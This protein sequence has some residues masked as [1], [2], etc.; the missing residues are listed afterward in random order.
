MNTSIIKKD[1]WKS[2]EYIEFHLD[3][4]VIYLYLMSCPDKG[5][6]NVFKFNKHIASLCTGVSK[7]SIEA[8]LE[9]LEAKGFIEIYNDYI[10]LLK[11]H[12]TAVGGQYGGVNK[13]RELASLPVDVREHFSLD[14]GSIIDIEPAKKDI[15]KPG[16]SPETIKDII[17]K[18]PK[19]LQRAL[20]EFVADRIERKKAPTTRAVKG[21]ITKLEGMYPNRPEQQAE[22]IM[23]SIE[24]GWMGL[25]EVK[26]NDRT[27]EKR[28]FM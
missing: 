18:Q 3:T 10:G 6:L 13:L 11:G 2:D 21:W 4:K 12:T 19:P 24:R 16:P 5:Y 8:G 7:N 14:D 23:Q 27:S 9:Q 28:E 22:S 20:S 17:S 15:K 26:N 25:F 1:F